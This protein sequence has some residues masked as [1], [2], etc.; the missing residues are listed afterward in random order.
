M[1][2][3]NLILYFLSQ[4]IRLCK[5]TYHGNELYQANRL[6]DI[7]SPTFNTTDYFMDYDHCLAISGGGSCTNGVIAW[8]RPSARLWDPIVNTKFSNGRR[9]SDCEYEM[10]A[11][12]LKLRNKMKQLDYTFTIIQS[13]CRQPLSFLGG[14]TFEIF[15][16]NEF[17][18]ASCVSV[19]TNNNSYNIICSTP[20]YSAGNSGDYAIQDQR[21][22]CMNITAVLNYE[23]LDVYS[24]VLPFER[25]RYHYLSPRK[26][27]VDNHQFCFPKTFYEETVFTSSVHINS[28]NTLLS[29][30][31]GERLSWYSAAWFNRHA[32]S[33]NLDEK[34]FDHN[35]YYGNGTYHTGYDQAIISKTLKNFS[36]VYPNDQAMGTLSFINALKPQELAVNYMYEVS[37]HSS[38]HHHIGGLKL[39]KNAMIHAQKTLFITEHDIE[40]YFYGDSHQRHFF[41]AVVEFTEGSKALDNVVKKHQ[42]FQSRNYIFEWVALVDDLSDRLIERCESKNIPNENSPQNYKILLHFAHWDLSSAGVRRFLHHHISLPKF[43]RKLELI[44]N[45]T[46]T[47]T[48]LVE[49]IWITTVPYPV[50]FD[51]T[52]NC[53]KPRG[54][55]NNP[56]I[57]AG[58]ELVLDS[59][60]SYRITQS[61]NVKLTIVDGHSMIKSRLGFNENNEVVCN[62]HFICRVDDWDQKL[63]TIVTPG[64]KA[65]FDAIVHAMAA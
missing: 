48:G 63:S 40:Y 17:S 43:I 21:S 16:F 44:F 53:L 6:F 49:I 54:Y 39:D 12:N 7:T 37:R 31:W 28:L 30:H 18:L 55:R 59:L 5:C 65:T 32:I 14:S 29:T 57:E 25:E 60:A 24:E 35:V 10:L 22:L 11:S 41:D 8:H 2:L 58:I 61:H 45:G 50:C 64:G 46:L 20:S 42:N 23:H 27:I 52:K 33:S 1:I 56:A 13:S 15:G 62:N 34:I 19:D 9:S 47:C 4:F 51:D 3:I 38:K 26:V 36:E